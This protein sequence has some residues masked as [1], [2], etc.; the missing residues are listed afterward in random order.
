M[1]SPFWNLHCRK[2]GEINTYV[3]NK[4]LCQ[5]YALWRKGKEVKGK[6]NGGGGCCSRVLRG[7]LSEQVSSVLGEI[8]K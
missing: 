8:K 2:E 4:T 3:C 5:W 1:F 7:G 6:E